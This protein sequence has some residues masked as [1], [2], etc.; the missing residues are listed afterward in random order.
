ML[1]PGISRQYS[2]GFRADYG[3][4]VNINPADDQ[5]SCVTIKIEYEEK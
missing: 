4:G 5:N 3:L 2:Y 1:V